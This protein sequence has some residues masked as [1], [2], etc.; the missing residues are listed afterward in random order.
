M[1]KKTW[2]LERT[3]PECSSQVFVDRAY[4]IH[5]IRMFLKKQQAIPMIPGKKIR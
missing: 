3:I 4:A 1:S 2:S 5:A